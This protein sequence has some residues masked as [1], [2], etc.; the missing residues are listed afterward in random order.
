MAKKT[1]FDVRG[2]K[3]RDTYGNTYHTAEV[4]KYDSKGKEIYSEKSD[5]TYGYDDAYTQTASKIM[6]PKEKD[7]S[8]RSAKWVNDRNDGK[9][10]YY[11]TNVDKK[12]DL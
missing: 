9:I 4:T 12:R 10:D 5:V 3:W 8:K 11:A 2:K 7:S 6:Y 1:I